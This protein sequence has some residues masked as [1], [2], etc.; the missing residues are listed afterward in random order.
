MT[1]TMDMD[2]DLR[3]FE[4]TA[5]MLVCLYMLVL[6]T[7]G[8]AGLTGR[9]WQEGGISFWHFVVYAPVEIASK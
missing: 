7:G 5:W 8:L 3:V 6:E 9:W 4:G 2:T 1:W